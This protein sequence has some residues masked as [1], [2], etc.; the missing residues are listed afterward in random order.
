MAEWPK[1][2][3]LK[4][5][6][7][8]PSVGSNPTLSANSINEWISSREWHIRTPQP[9]AGL[10]SLNRGCGYADSSYILEI[11]QT[12]QGMEVRLIGRYVWQVDVVDVA[13][14]LA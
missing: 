10:L 12:V 6:E 3:V 4:T 14:G 5:V 9:R 2:A 13:R 11:R 8:K 7:G 1:A